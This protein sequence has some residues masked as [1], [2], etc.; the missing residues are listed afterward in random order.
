[1]RTPSRLLGAA[2]CGALHLAMPAAAHAQFGGLA[3]K[4]LEKAVEKKVESKTTE[5]ARNTE[6]PSC[7]AC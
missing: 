3:K 7:R 4:A 5:N 6:S 1:M 2:A